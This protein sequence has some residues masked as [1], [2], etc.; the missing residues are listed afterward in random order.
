ME[1]FVPVIV[2]VVLLLIVV[3]NIKVVPQSKAYVLERLGAYAGTWQTG[4][5]FKI[6]FI[7]R[8][9]KIVSLKEQVVDFP[10]QPVITK[11]NVTM[12]I[13]TVVFFQI[14]DPKLFTY[15][16]ESPITAIENLS[17]TT[18]RN[19]I[20]EMELDNTLTSRDVINS[21]I[22]VI[23]DT[24]TDPWGI[25]VNR[26]ELK[27]I[28][29]PQ[30]IQDAMEKQMKAERQRREAILQAEGEKAAKI[31]A[32]E[33]LKESQILAAEGEK[34]AAILRAD[35]VKEARIR[36]AD[37]EAQ[38][39]RALYEAQAESIRMINEA[40]P[41]AAYITLKSYE[42][43]EKAADGKA[44]KIIVPSEIQSLASLLTAAKESVTDPEKK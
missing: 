26:V 3:S 7:D 12:R 43:F 11:D 24:A 37:G 40:K 23:L 31:L 19:I 1:W 27:N 10:P 13:D 16:V 44:T 22:R 6:P 21:K 18:L 29:P 14:T 28:M 4:L 9:A 2:I 5:H 38:A 17:A 41:E 15:G 33:G 32:A 42:A 36:E 34:Q 8:I 20:G 30:E 39:I 25:K 35:A